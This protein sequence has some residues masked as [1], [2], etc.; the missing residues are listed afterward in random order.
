MLPQYLMHF[1]HET[2]FDEGSLGQDN[3]WSPRLSLAGDFFNNACEGSPSVW[4][5]VLPQLDEKTSQNTGKST[6]KET[7]IFLT[8][9]GARQVG[10][11]AIKGTY[12]EFLVTALEAKSSVATDIE[13]VVW[14]SFKSF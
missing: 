5:Q 6:V 7:L 13:A 8:A 1:N 11:K 12:E 10:F 4:C 9:Y 2:S 14:I 3:I